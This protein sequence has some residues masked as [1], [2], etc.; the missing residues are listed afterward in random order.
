MNSTPPQDSGIGTRLRAARER[1]G[2]TREALAFYSG[3]SWPAI[4]QV[5][6]GR[7]R[8]VRPDTLSALTDALGVTIDYLVRGVPT[9]APMLDHSALL[10]GSDEEL[11]DVAGPFLT[12]G[13][14]R[15]EA[16]LAV[17]TGANI[18]LLRGH[19]GNGAKK[20]EFLDSTNETMYG[21]PAA[22]L[23]SYRRF[24]KANLDS[25]APWVRVFA[26]PAWGRSKAE[27][28]QWVQYESLFNLV[29]AAAPLTVVCAYDQRSLAPGIVT[30]A[31]HTHPRM[32]GAGAPADSS[33]YADPGD[34]L[35]GP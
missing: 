31:C 35:L 1:R 32:I 2:W 33:D 16:T 4:A 6:S 30:Q 3:V 34:Y 15:G 25:G 13:T 28:R 19:L 21:G 7:R 8:H 5:E 22:A 10:Y 17:T 29:F 11:L 24:L 26:Q 18:D 12:E 9:A 20:I 14:E 23:D 27:V